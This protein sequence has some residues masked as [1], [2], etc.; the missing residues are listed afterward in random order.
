MG[1][2][3][4]LKSFVGADKPTITFTRCEDSIPVTDTGVKYRLSV[5]AE[6]PLTVVSLESS[7]I[8]RT[9]DDKKMEQNETLATE[10][11]NGSSWSPEDNPFPGLLDKGKDWPVSGM[12][13]MNDA[14]SKKVQELYANRSSNGF[15][16]ILKATLDIKETGG[17]FDPS[18]EREITFY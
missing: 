11:D 12:V 7:L 6:K 14:A 18:V 4:K 16:L 3:D 13:F 15:K 17:L 5:T 10:K 1:F 2:F 8:A 9:I